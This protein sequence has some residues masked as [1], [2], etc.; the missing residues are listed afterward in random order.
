MKITNHDL[1][2]KIVQIDEKLD[3]IIKATESGINWQITHDK[4]DDDRF[5]S[6]NR[7][8]ISIAI[9]STFCGAVGTWLW[10][11]IT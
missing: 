7:F 6:L 1:H 9:V 4:K 3:W 11:K 10:Q 8:G 2:L 5:N